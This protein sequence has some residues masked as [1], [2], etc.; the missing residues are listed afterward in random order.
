M[1]KQPAHQKISFEVQP[2]TDFGK[3]LRKYQHHGIAAGNI[4]GPNFTSKAI[5]IQL[6][7]FYAVYKQVHETGVVYLQLDGEEIPALIRHI[8]L[9]P[10]DRHVQHIDF[11]KIDLKQKIETEVPVEIVGESEA[12]TVHSGV[13]LKQTDHL[14]VEALPQNIP[15]TID[16]DITVLKEVGSDIKVKDLPVSP[17]YV[18]K[19]DPE[20]VIISVTEHKEESI[21]PDTETAAPVITEE[22]PEESTEGADASDTPAAENK[23]ESE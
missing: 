20:R 12:V 13:L 16:V 19:E 22:Q 8:Q 2:R 4:F 9:H 17:D 6:K 5:T 21:V 7:D 11:R 23:P 14:I 3:K 1:A 15:Q 18:F 10:V